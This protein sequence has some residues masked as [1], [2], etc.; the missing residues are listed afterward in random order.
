MKKAIPSY[1]GIAFYILFRFTKIYYALVAT[2]FGAAD[3]IASLA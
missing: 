2:V 3:L 1:N